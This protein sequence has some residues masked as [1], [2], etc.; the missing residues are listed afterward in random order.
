MGH[1]HSLHK[2]C[3]TT[4][5]S[6]SSSLSPESEQTKTKSS[7]SRPPILA[8]SSGSVSC[9]AITL[10]KYQS[11][12][13][14]TEEDAKLFIHENEVYWTIENPIYIIQV[15]ERNGQT[16]DELRD[17]DIVFSNRVRVIIR[18]DVISEIVAFDCPW[19]VDK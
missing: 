18:N 12:L 3:S 19:L 15:V 9:T 14:M 13:G 5:S 1:T 7:N 10:I 11:L 16:V 6:S 8:S 2:K 17:C 4:S